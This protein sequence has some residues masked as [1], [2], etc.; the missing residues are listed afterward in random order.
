MNLANYLAD[1]DPAQVRTVAYVPAEARGDA[2]LVAMACDHLVM[3]P[4]AILGGPGAQD[5]TPEELQLTRETLRDTL[6]PKKSRSWSLPAALLDPAL[7]VFRFTHKRDGVVEFFCEEEL[8]AQPD[9]DSWVRGEEVTPNGAALSATGEQAH[10][11]GLARNVVGDFESFKRL[12]GLESDLIVAEP[13]WADEL[14]E[15]LAAPFVAYLLLLI[16]GAA[17]YVELQAPG[18]GIGGFVAGVCFLLYFWSKHLGGTAD[19]L[20]V[21]LFASGV[22]CVLIEIF[23]LPGTAIF[24]LG[25]GL[26]VIASIVLA[27]QT[28]VVPHNEYQLSQLRDSLLGLIL[29]GIGVVVIAVLLRRWLPHTPLFRQVVLAPPSDEE[30]EDLAHREALAEFDYLLGHQ[31]QATTQLTPSGKAR[32]GGKLVDVIA[33]GEVIGRGTE[34]VVVAVQGNRVVVRSVAGDV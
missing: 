27:S 2:A 11:L 4:D 22:A 16:G 19:W 20:E 7:R 10:S 24:G 8:K 18:V 26:L 29:V 34:V 9:P 31:G 33:D 30:L 5:F 1:L 12:Y 17:L 13:G 23:V 32:F 15:A 14:V 21:L 28:F 3:D 25:G 6:G